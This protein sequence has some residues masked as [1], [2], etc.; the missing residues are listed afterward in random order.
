LRENAQ[1]CIGDALWVHVRARCRLGPLV[2]RIN[3]IRTGPGSRQRIWEGLLLRLILLV[4]L[5]ASAPALDLPAGPD[6]P[7]HAT[8][9]R[10]LGAWLSQRME[11]P[12][13]AALPPAGQGSV[14]DI[15]ALL[16]DPSAKPSTELLRT[17]RTLRAGRMDVDPVAGIA[18]AMVEDRAL[19]PQGWTM[20]LMRNGAKSLAQDHRLPELR[21]LAEMGAL[22]IVA[23]WPDPPSVDDLRERS[24]TTVEEVLCAPSDE[25]AERFLWWM[26]QRADILQYQG[27]TSIE[28]VVANAHKA[29]GDGSWLGCMLAASLQQ[30]HLTT[31]PGPTETR[32]AAERAMVDSYAKAHA[33]HPDRPEAA[34]E[35]LR[36][37]SAL[38][39]RGQDDDGDGDD[40]ETWFVR[41]VTAELDDQDAY[42]TMVA[43]VANCPTCRNRFARAC[44]ATG[45]FDTIVPLGYLAVNGF[46]A[47]TAWTS[48][49]IGYVD[50]RHGRRHDDLERLITGYRSGPLASD[51]RLHLLEAEML[52]LEGEPA[53]ATEALKAV[54]DDIDVQDGSLLVQLTRNGRPLA[55]LRE[56]AD[57]RALAKDALDSVDSAYAQ[58]DQG[59]ALTRL[60]ALLTDHS[61]DAT[62]RFALRYGAAMQLGQS[63]AAIQDPSPLPLVATYGH[64]QALTWLLDHGE[65]VDAVDREG[66]TALQRAAQHNGLDVIRKLLAHGANIEATDQKGRT[67]LHLVAGMTQVPSTIPP[68]FLQQMLPQSLQTLHLLL[69]NGAKVNAR[70]HE[71]RMPVQYALQRQWAE[72]VAALVLAGGLDGLSAEEGEKV[73]KEAKATPAGVAIVKRMSAAKQGSNF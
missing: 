39:R 25:G 32:L 14:S 65:P 63:P 26:W 43:C 45:R 20:I 64:M 47:Q 52:L 16:A 60:A 49:R 23:S 21:F 57:A 35:I 44:L 13:R 70:D 8:F 2:A 38:D 11:A 4:P 31:A 40:G 9:Q 61:T 58:G 73:L 51:P 18:Y 36:Q 41:V 22:A 15:I 5:T 48:N 28:R 17:M 37:R 10:A 6:A 50:W 72:G 19:G 24:L 53:R 33:L 68:A 66:Y 71:Q 30:L 59:L 3:R 46:S 69:D 67:A 56:E 42:R 1:S 62:R 27:T 34:L 12:M 7:L 55:M 29:H 54:P